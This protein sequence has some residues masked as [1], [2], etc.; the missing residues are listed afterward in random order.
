MSP[1]NATTTALPTTATTMYPKHG[2]TH[3]TSPPSVPTDDHP[4]LSGHGY[5]LVVGTFGVVNGEKRRNR[6][7]LLTTNTELNAMAAPAISGLSR[8]SAASGMAARL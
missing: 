3:P 8:P 4:T 7:L 5:Q 2:R 1:T 6:R